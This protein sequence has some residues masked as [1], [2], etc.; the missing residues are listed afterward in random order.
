MRGLSIYLSI[1]LYV[2]LYIYLSSIYLSLSPSIYLFIYVCMYQLDYLSFH[3]SLF[4]VTYFVCFF[5]I[6]MNI[7]N[8]HEVQCQLLPLPLHRQRRQTNKQTSALIGAFW[9]CYIPAF[10]WNCDRQTDRFTEPP[11][12]RRAWE[13]IW[14]TPFWQGKADLHTFSASWTD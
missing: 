9:K 10:L 14:K 11:N 13:L 7:V 5:K 3:M 1:Y 2:Y 12:N 8:V 6:G 4:T